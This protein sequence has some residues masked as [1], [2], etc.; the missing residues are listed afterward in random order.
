MT[1]TP[2]TYNWGK[3]HPKEVHRTKGEHRVPTR[4][5][6][7]TTQMYQ[8]NTYTHGHSHGTLRYRRTGTDQGRIL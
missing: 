1:D 6:Q 7:V 3:K 2:K 5:I 8:G 4:E